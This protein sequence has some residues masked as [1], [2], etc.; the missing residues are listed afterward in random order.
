[1]D[2]RLPGIILT[3][4]GLVAIVV[5]LT[6]GPNLGISRRAGVVIGIVML[7][8]GVLLLVGAFS[9]GTAIR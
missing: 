4:T 2:Q 1:M 5:S 3:V 7:S 9:G 8:V 6:R